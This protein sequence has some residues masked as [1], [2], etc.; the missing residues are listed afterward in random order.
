MACATPE[1]HKGNVRLYNLN[2]STM[3]ATVLKHDKKIQKCKKPHSEMKQ[4]VGLF[5]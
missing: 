1:V 4:L 5:L 3:S 2:I